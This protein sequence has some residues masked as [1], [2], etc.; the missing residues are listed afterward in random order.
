[1]SIL[2]RSSV[3]V[4]ALVLTAALAATACGGSDTAADTTDGT[5]TTS[6][7]AAPAFTTTTEGE[8]TTTT[9][10][11]SGEEDTTVDSGD[12]VSVDYVGTLDDGEQFDTSIGKEPLTFTVGSGQMI[13]GFET[14][15]VGMEVGETKTVRLEPADAYGE[16]DPELVIDFPADQAP[17]GLT[18]GDQVQFSNGAIG[19]V[20]EVNDE[21]VKVDANHPLAGEALNFEITVVSVG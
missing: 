6:S 19:T 14:A 3:R 15:V 2:Q 21:F 11:G 20:L 1:V 7:T 12:T 4:L 13:P 8:T 5:T 17:D 10:A 16:V 18:A 9:T